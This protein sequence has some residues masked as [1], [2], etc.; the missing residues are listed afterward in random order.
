MAVR[1]VYIS[2]LIH[3][4]VLC[5]TSF[6][7]DNTTSND[8]SADFPLEANF[9]ANSTFGPILLGTYFALM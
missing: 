7:M 1:N 4:T 8:G 3:G 5:T 6:A 2:R 9:S